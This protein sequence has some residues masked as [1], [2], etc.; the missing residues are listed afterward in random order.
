[1]QTFFNIYSQQATAQAVIKD[2]VQQCQ[3]APAEANFAFIYATDALTADFPDLLKQCKDATG[4]THWVGTIGLGIIAP[5]QEWYDNPAASIMLAAFDETEFSMLPSIKKIDEISPTLQAIKRYQ[6]NVALIHGDPFNPETQELIE[7]TQQQ[8]DNGFIVGGLASSRDKH[9]QVSD[10]IDSG[11]ISGVI[12][13]EKINVISNL[14]QGCSPVGKKLSITKAQEN[15]AFTIDN[16][17]ALNVLMQ[18]M[19]IPDFHALKDQAAE[20]FIGICIP[21]SDSNDYMVRNLVGIDP[22]HSIFAINDYLHEGDEIVF[23]RRNDQTAIDDMQHMLDKLADRLK[24]LPIKGG[25]YV[26][27][28]GRGR[29]QFGKNSEE[30]KMIHNTLG[31]FPLTGFFANG[32]IH[33]NKLYGY[34]GVLTLFI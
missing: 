20:V 24:K 21:G 19:G 9:Y 23:C 10:S 32:E 31:D 11:G 26:S 27:C 16:Q 28:L 17:L 4:I 22:E 1:M 12:F 34:T 25:I 13:S 29:E 18:K 3:N 15:V 14:T 7:Q 5:N 30:V 33:H 2:C 8:L 6:V